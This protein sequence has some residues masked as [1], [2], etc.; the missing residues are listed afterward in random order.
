MTFDDVA[1]NFS[2]EEW[3]CLDSAQQDFY[4]DVMWRIT[5]T[6][7]LWVRTASLR[8]VWPTLVN[9]LWGVSLHIFTLLEYILDSCLSG[10]NELLLGINKIIM[11]CL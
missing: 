11:M 3:E 1:V 6:C 8:G 5:E 9:F 4:R 10:R 7:C 2:P